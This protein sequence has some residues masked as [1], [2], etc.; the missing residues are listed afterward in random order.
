MSPPELEKE[1]SGT[2]GL[3]QGHTFWKRQGPC[4]DPGPSGGSCPPFLWLLL[5]FYSRG[6]WGAG[7]K[8]R[9]RSHNS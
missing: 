2:K 7:G 3:S 8:A 9:S 4:L 6:H 1:P 5:L